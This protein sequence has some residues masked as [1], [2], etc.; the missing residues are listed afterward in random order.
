MLVS[1]IISEVSTDIF[2][3][4]NVRWSESVLLNFYNSAER[5]IVYFKPTSY[6]VSGVYELVEGTKQDLP[7][8]TNS[9]QDPDS[10]TLEQ[11]IELIRVLRNMGT[12][13]ETVGD[14]VYTVTPA[15]MDELYPGWRTATA[16]ATVQNVVYDPKIRIGFEV[17]PPQ[18]SSDM[19]WLEIIYSGVP[20]AITSTGQ[21]MNLRSEYAEPIKNYM[22][23]RVYSLDAL[24]SQYAAS[25]AISYW[26]LFLAQIGKKELIEREY[27]GANSGNSDKPV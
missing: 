11:S 2:D 20:T 1:S 25:Q 4:N 14:D 17:Y 15:D 10:N 3:P 12:D 16:S 23:H 7:D 24:N 13:G 21:N 9:F 18:P 27:R 8:G 22:K 26:N 5:Q 19:G 6:I